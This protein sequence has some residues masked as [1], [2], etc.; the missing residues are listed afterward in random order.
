MIL[1][2]KSKVIYSDLWANSGWDLQTNVQ[3]MPEFQNNQAN[4]DLK[5]YTPD[6]KAC[7]NFLVK[8][9]AEYYF[10]ITNGLNLSSYIPIEQ[11]GK[12]IIYKRSV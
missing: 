10:S 2:Y 11:F 4:M 9:N 5:D 8:N 3:M 12:V 1:H 6:S 7:N